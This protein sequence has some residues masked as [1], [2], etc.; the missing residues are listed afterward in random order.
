MLLE[1]VLHRISVLNSQGELS[2]E[3]S[4]IVFDSRKAIDSAMY[5][6]MKGGSGWTPVY[7]RCNRERS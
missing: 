5:V 6:A 4:K 1:K 3:V 7:K 2:L